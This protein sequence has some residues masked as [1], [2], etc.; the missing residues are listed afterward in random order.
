M[1]ALPFFKVVQKTSLSW[2]LGGDNILLFEKFVLIFY[3]LTL[4][5]DLEL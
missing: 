5:K 1:E 2:E 3:M 4:K